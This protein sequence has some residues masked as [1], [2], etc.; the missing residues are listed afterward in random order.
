[1]HDYNIMVTIHIKPYKGCKKCKAIY[2]QL[3]F[4]KKYIKIQFPQKVNA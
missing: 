4:Q 2:N 1:M 3:L